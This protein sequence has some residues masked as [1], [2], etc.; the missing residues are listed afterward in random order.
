MVAHIPSNLYETIWIDVETNPSPGCS[1]SGHDA[2][3]NCAFLMETANAIKAKGKKVGM[4]ASRYMWGTIFGSYDA[5]G[6]ASVGIPLWY[7]HYDNNPSFADFTAF[8]GWKTPNIKQYLGT[9][10]LCGA[11][12]DRNWHP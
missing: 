10:T 6:Q 4:Y 3:S 1:W 8:A 11:G 9:S 2:A 12:V 5:C 7:A